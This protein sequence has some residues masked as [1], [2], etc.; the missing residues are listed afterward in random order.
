MNGETFFKKI[1]ASVMP[2]KSGITQVD[3]GDAP[4]TVGLARLCHSYMPV[5]P[6]WHPGVT[7]VIQ[8]TN[9]RGL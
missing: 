3:H 5:E 1:E 4:V 8:D 6:R 9:K 2:V 7:S